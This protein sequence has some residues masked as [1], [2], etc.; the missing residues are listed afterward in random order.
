MGDFTRAELEDEVRFRLGNRTDLDARITSATKFAYDELVTSIRVPENQE[1]AVLST[2]NLQSVY[3]TPLDMYFPVSIRNSTDGERLTPLSIRNYERIRGTT[4]ANKP[5]FYVWWRDEIILEPR[6]DATVRII[7]MRFLKRLAALTLATTVSALPRE[8][9][10]VIIQGSYIRALRWLQL[11]TEAQA[12]QAEYI[13][14]V[15]RRIDRIAGGD[16]DTETTAE[17]L[18]TEGTALLRGM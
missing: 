1:T 13:A 9:D 5:K 2:V 10:E 15:T 11:K 7:R 6:A 18:L 14:M 17:P 12:E 8:W 3:P 16:A 4:L